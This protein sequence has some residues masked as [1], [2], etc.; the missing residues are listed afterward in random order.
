MP[1]LKFFSLHFLR[2]TVAS[3][4]AVDLGCRY[5]GNDQSAY[6]SC[7]RIDDGN[8]EGPRRRLS[9]KHPRVYTDYYQGRYCDGAFLWTSY[10]DIPRC[11]GTTAMQCI[12]RPDTPAFMKKDALVT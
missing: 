9:S 10:T 11:D 5:L 8:S 1:I 4:A 6:T 7:S 2:F 3:I 12:D